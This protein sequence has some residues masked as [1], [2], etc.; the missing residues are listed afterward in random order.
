MKQSLQNNSWV[1]VL[2]NINIDI[3]IDRPIEDNYP[4][5]ENYQRSH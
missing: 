3:D 1:Q 2:N 5:N 4:A